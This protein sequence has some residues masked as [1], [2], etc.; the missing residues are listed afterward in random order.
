MVYVYILKCQD[1]TYYTGWT[2]DLERRTRTHNR[3]RGA[4]YTRS[5]LP[6][7][8]VYWEAL[9]DKSSALKR[10]QAIKKMSRIQKETLLKEFK[11]QEQEK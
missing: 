1:A 4:K 7:H 10:E 9:A 3:G 6:V 5:R 8:L 11:N 2:T